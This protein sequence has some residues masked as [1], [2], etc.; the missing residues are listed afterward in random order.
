M[1]IIMNSKSKVTHTSFG[2]LVCLSLLL[3]LNSCKSNKRD[4]CVHYSNQQ[5]FQIFADFLQKK[6]KGADIPLEE[7]QR[8]EKAIAV[9]SNGKFDIDVIPITASVFNDSHK[10]TH[11]FIKGNPVLFYSVVD[12]TNRIETVW[13]DKG[14]PETPR[15]KML[16][17]T[18]NYDHL[19]P[20]RCSV[21][22][23]ICTWSFYLKSGRNLHNNLFKLQG[24]G[25]TNDAILEL[26]PTFV[27]ALVANQGELVFKDY[28]KNILARIPLKA[29]KELQREVAGEVAAV[30]AEN[31]PS[32]WAV[33]IEKL[34][35][36]NLHKVSDV[37][38][39]G[40]Q[41]TAEGFKELEKM[42]IKTVINL[43]S[44]HSDRDKLKG[45]SLGYE[46][47]R[48]ETWDPELDEVV[49]ALKVMTDK[50]KQP[51][52]VHC[53][54]GADRTGTVVAIYRIMEQ[55]WGKEKTI[56]E[57]REGGF[58]YHEMWKGLPKFIRGLDIEE[59]KGKL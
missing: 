48:V 23:T 7:A 41:P 49:R 57:M 58:G 1:N 14:G 33:P 51:V 32:D 28:D 6:Y 16:F 9:L 59:L 13:Y 2:L 31:R 5:N 18:K 52:F 47:I 53:M 55:G 24:I 20:E 19:F 50:E 46:H 4:T 17:Y 37:L 35:C 40:E 36:G 42:G 11:P 39:R 10:Y 38:Y 21:W 54:H 27:E 34:G 26:P 29:T 56:K 12:E 30:S 15:H 45:T 44:F 22:T 8:V 25:G 43:R 3:G